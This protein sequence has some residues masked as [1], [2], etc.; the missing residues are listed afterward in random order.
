MSQGE[1]SA[2]ILSIYLSCPSLLHYPHVYV[3]AP[4][5]PEA[6]ASPNSVGGSPGY[7]YTHYLLIWLKNDRGVNTLW[8]G[9]ISNEDLKLLLT[10]DE[11]NKQYRMSLIKV[12]GKYSCL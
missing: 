11:Q 4:Q 10:G 7:R 9:V 2:D 1:I 8:E 5:Q 12:L 6:A 3:L